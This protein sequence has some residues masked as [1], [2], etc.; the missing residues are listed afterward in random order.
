MVEI[1]V[2]FGNADP[3]IV[4]AKV[5]EGVIKAD[6]IAVDLEAIQLCKYLH[7]F[8]LNFVLTDLDR[9]GR[10]IKCWHLLSEVSACNKLV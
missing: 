3:G 9:K 5:T 1:G 4:T 2:Q 6:A 8:W 7:K 10:N